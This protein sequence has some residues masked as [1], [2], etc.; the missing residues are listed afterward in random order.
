MTTVAHEQG[1]SLVEALVAA[2]IVSTGVLTM[3][4]L[5]SIAT[6]TNLAARRSTVATIVAEQ[7]LEELRAL[8]WEY[9]QASPSAT[10]QQNT[11]GYVDYIGIFTRR[12]SIEPVLPIPD[13]A[14]VI[15]VL[16][17]APNDENR[18]GQGAVSRLRGHARIVTVRSRKAQ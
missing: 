9:L 6:A 1:S 2:L 17:T 4:Q 14:F 3:A 10:L 15:Q 7:K 18:I 13:S 5:L 12:W 8:P 11:D 16:V